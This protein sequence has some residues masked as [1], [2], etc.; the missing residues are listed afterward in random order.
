M[1]RFRY[2]AAD[3]HGQ[4]REGEL[5]AHH[6][7]DLD[8]RLRLLQLLEETNALAEAR[9]IRALANAERGVERG[10]R[11]AALHAQAS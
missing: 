6:V 3:A 7:D 2:R 8:L 10:L 9:A 5:E 11:I 1:T 4:L